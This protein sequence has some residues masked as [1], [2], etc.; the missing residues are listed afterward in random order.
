[1]QMRK[2]QNNESKGEGN[3]PLSY[4]RSV[5]VSEL[6]QQ[7]VSSIV[8]EMKDLDARLVTVMGASLT[9]DLLSCK[10]YYSV[11]GSEEDK[12]KIAGVLKKSTKQVR[13]KLAL[14]LDLRRTP[15]ISFVYDDTN[16]R[17]TKVFDILQ[18]IEEEKGKSIF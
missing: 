15:T 18:K 17:A 4:K 2:V 14:R 16:E 10:I 7:T 12:K 6:I 11:L 3:M 8:R 1:M 5:R 13:H 9:D